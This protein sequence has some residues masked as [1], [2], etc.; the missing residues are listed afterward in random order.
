MVL[1]KNDGLLPLKRTVKRIAVV[2]PLAA[3]IAVLLGNYHN[4]TAQP[5]VTALDGIRA[6]FPAHRSPLC[7]DHVSCVRLRRCQPRPA[8]DRGWP[9]RREGR[10]FPS[11]DLSGAATIA[12]CDA[13][14]TAHSTGPGSSRNAEW[15]RRSSLTP[16]G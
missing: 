7:S 12:R 13:P 3:E 5:A 9:A 11:P 8:Q 10:Y 15:W 2:G 16:P 1:L 14:L 4:G 6:A